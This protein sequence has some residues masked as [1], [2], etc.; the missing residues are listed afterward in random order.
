VPLAPK[1]DF[2]WWT[3]KPFTFSTFSL[4][5]Q[6]YLCPG[7]KYTDESQPLAS[8]SP[9]NLRLTHCP[10]MCTMVV[11]AS[12]LQTCLSPILVGTLPAVCTPTG[13]ERKS[14]HGELFVAWPGAVAVQRWTVATDQMLWTKNGARRRHTRSQVPKFNVMRQARWGKRVRKFQRPL[15][16]N[17]REWSGDQ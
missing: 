6:S 14:L 16:A 5:W 8:V 3:Q 9:M 13:R 4:E 10:G 15:R 11:T 17:N 1:S 7:F 12:A 2:K